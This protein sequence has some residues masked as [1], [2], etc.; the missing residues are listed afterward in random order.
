MFAI[1]Q[2]NKSMSEKGL[3][4]VAKIVYPVLSYLLI[5]QL[6]T[7]AQTSPNVDSLKQALLKARNVEDSTGIL[8]KLTW[9]TAESNPDEKYRYGMKAFELS[10]RIKNK[11]RLAE[12]YDAVALVYWVKQDRKTAR[13]FYA[14]SLDIGEKYNFIRRVAWG[15][16]NLAQLFE[17]ENKTVEARTYALK[18]RAAFKQMNNIAMTIYSDWII[19]RSYNKTQNAYVDSTI[20]DYEIAESRTIDT[21]L[22]LDQYLNLI[23]LYGWKENKSKSMFYAMKVL[24]LAEETKNDKAIIKAYYQIGDYLRDY[25]HN[26]DVALLYYQK[27][28]D[29]SERNKI[30]TGI[31]GVLI[32]IGNVYKLMGKDSLAYINFNKSLEIAKEINHR[33][34]I[35]NAYKSIGEISYEKKNYKKALTYYMKCWETG[36]DKCPRITFHK[37]LIDIGNVYLNEKDYHNAER[38]FRKSLLLADSANTNYERA[39]SYSALADI[40]M[41]QNNPGSAVNCFHTA[42]NLATEVNALSLRKEISSKLSKAYKQQNNFQKAFEYLDLSNTL[43]DSLNKMSEAENLSRLET[44][45][46]FQNMKMQKE[47]ELKESRIQA[48][49]EIDKQTQ[50]KYFF[51]IGFILVTVLG[52]VVY[53]NFRRKRADNLILEL[54]KKQLEELSEKIHE[55]DQKKLNFFTNISHEIRTPLTLILGPVEKLIKESLSNHDSS[56]LLNIIRRNTLQ[57][58]NLINQLLD[59]RK[60]DTGNVRLNVSHGDIT[61]YCKGV[62]STFIHLAEEKDIIFDFNATEEKLVGWFD[63]DIIEK[64]LNNLFSNAFK[65][66]PRNGK[67]NVSISA[68]SSN[69]QEISRVKIIVSDN[70]KGIPEDQVQYVFDR[71]YQVEN[72]N[73][74]FNTGTG[75][76]LAYTKELIELHKGEIS[77]DSRINQ[78]TTFSILLPIDESFY[79]E[80]E[81][82]INSNGVKEIDSDNVRQKYLQQ[83]IEPEIE[84]I[85]NFILTNQI[86]ERKMMLIIEDNADLRTFIKSIFKEDFEIIEASDGTAGLRWATEL[87][88]DVIISDIMMPGMNGLELC[89]KLKNSIHTNHIPILILTAKAGEGD[90]IEGLKTGAD[91]YLTKPFNSEILEMRIK[92]LISS[93]ER[94]KEYFAREFLLNP[95]EVKL[96]SLDDEFLKRAVQ[97]VEEN[98]SNPDLNVE[99]LMNKLGVSRTQLF[100]KLKAV[101]NYSASQFIR[102]IKL[103][104]AAQLLQYKSYNITEVLYLS[105]FN[106][107]SYFTACFKEMYGCLPKEYHSRIDDTSVIAN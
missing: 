94:L 92:R 90:E 17:L 64:T 83:L 47:L 34:S 56:T 7:S 87:I 28:L 69:E 105:G 68:V 44:K 30:K 37:V 48:N 18:S 99:M 38:Y 78:G 41:S 35:A 40:F 58:Y 86:S 15:S 31:P 79:S 62:Y 6:S 76:G 20:N 9:Y 91:D 81:K 107:P 3:H 77:I 96:T 46:E 101:T 11:E 85:E 60:L 26:Y 50:Q 66:T 14:K 25:Q 53:R 19:V 22:R 73:T 75:I 52:L 70:G 74:G 10:K 45:F 1:S 103:K 95:K 49:V 32:D 16:Y 36:C 51:I 71:Y 80:T 59:I 54:Q 88:P 23:I 98:I 24:D 106:S 5:F 8:T 27:I 29:L 93:R 42:L 12:I 72:S 84:T 33:H 43:T 65:Y 89:N 104:R 55:A 4:K 57:L 97:I 67:I 13:E 63:K 2:S 39:V 61:G 100:R 102:N 21:E 82:S